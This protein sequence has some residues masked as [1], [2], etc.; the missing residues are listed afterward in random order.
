MIHSL[1]V[2]SFVYCWNHACKRIKSLWLILPLIR[3]LKTHARTTKA[4]KWGHYNVPMFKVLLESTGRLSYWCIWP[5]DLVALSVLVFVGGEFRPS[6]CTNQPS[7]AQNQYS[8]NHCGDKTIQNVA[9]YFLLMFILIW[10]ANR[11]SQR[12]NPQQPAVFS[13]YL[14]LMFGRESGLTTL[15][16]QGS[17][18]ANI[19]DSKKPA[20]QQNGVNGPIWS[21]IGWV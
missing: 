11:Y 8:W 9:E 21:R 1:N 17:L 6:S 15:S 7:Q 16:Y 13:S 18:R 5:C 20:H 4:W 3:P 19:C 14:F 12:Q 10:P 2:I